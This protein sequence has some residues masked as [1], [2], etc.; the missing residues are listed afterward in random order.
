MIIVV[1]LEKASFGSDQRELIAAVS[2]A[3]TGVF[4]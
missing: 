4:E 2:L 1:Y 3:Q